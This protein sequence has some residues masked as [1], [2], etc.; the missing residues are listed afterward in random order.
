MDL[1]LLHHYTATTVKSFSD[2][3]ALHDKMLEILRNDVV[4]LA[5]EHGFLMDNILSLALIHLYCIDSNPHDVR[6]VAIYRDRAVH[7][8]RHAISNLHQQKLRPIMLASL[9]LTVSSLSGDRLLGYPGLWST[10]MLSVARGPRIFSQTFNVPPP[11]PKV[12]FL[13]HSS[14]PVSIDFDDLETPAAIPVE[15]EKALFMQ[16]V[17][18]NYIYQETLIQAAMSIGKLI[19]SL[20]LPHDQS[21][22]DFKIRTWPFRL[23]T[24]FVDLVRQRR[25]RALIVL[26]YYLVHLQFI[27]DMWLFDGV[28]VHDMDEISKILSSE[29]QEH[30]VVPKM[31][32]TFDNKA[33]LAAFLVSQLRPTPL[34]IATQ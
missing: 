26:A 33:A 16:D 25:P 4:Q 18:D 15:L 34:Q 28:A 29:W 31:A 7:T 1:R 19:S 30:L 23:P 32:L 8:F 13:R 27:K 17:D 10:N 5:F 24:Q 12:P 20:A 21:W 11:I 14:L 2:A 22:I 9:L 6:P 3:F